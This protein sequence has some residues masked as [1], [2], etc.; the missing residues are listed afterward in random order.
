MGGWTVK[1]VDSCQKTV[2]A[3]SDL[4]ESVLLSQ[5]ITES[6]REGFEAGVEPR[7]L[8]RAVLMS[9][10]D[11]MRRGGFTPT[12]AAIHLALHL[13]T[14]SRELEEALIDEPELWE[15]AQ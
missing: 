13:G 12:D 1:Y 3:A 2:D 5:G 10:M 15:T 4:A 14:I 9:A 8:V 11:L 7:D 6:L